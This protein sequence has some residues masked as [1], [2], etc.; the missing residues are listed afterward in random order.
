MQNWGLWAAW[1]LSETRRVP[2]SEWGVR[3]SRLTF[4]GLSFSLCK[5]GIRIV[6]TSDLL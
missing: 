4:L 5:M 1:R 6:A 3:A 2:G